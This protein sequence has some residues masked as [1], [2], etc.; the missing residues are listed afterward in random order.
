MLESARGALPR[1][2]EAIAGTPIE[3]SW[4]SHPQARR[5]YAALQFVADADEVFV[6]RLAAGKI[7]FVHAR[8][9]PALV[10]LADTLPAERTARVRQVHTAS[11][12]HVNE[13]TRY[14]R[15]VTPAQRAAAARLTPEQARAMLAP[16]L[17]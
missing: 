5:I 2:T 3:G 1:L 13:E 17:T 10:R 6:C 16:A 11:G 7:T 4:W 14:P 8:L 15:W 9:L 12:R